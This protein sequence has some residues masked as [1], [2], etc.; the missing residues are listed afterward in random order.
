MRLR[1]AHRDPD[2]GRART[3][4]RRGTSLPLLPAMNSSDPRP[5][6]DTKRPRTDGADDRTRT[7]VQQACD[8]ELA[9]KE[10]RARDQLANAEWHARADVVEMQARVEERFRKNR[11]RYNRMGKDARAL[12]PRECHA[13]LANDARARAHAMDMA[14][15]TPGATSR[16]RTDGAPDGK[17][18]SP[19]S[20]VSASPQSS[21]PTYLVTTVPF[22]TS[23]ISTTISL[24]EHLGNQK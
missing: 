14:N 15:P 21:K 6:K 2:S 7:A 23:E 20:L 18:G 17:D 22:P 19:R 13:I 8:G 12:S 4:L 11:S 24:R 1:I 3:A 16:P 10:W 5:T 9:N